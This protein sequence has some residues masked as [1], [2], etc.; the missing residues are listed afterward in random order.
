MKSDPF[1]WLIV[2]PSVLFVFL[3]LIKRFIPWKFCTVCGSIFL[4]WLILLVSDKIL[5]SAFLQDQILMTIL[6]GESVAG[7]YYLL[8]RTIPAQYHVF[9]FPILITLSIG[10][11]S[12]AR[13]SIMGLRDFIIL[14]VLWLVFILLALFSL[15]PVVR[16]RVSQLLACC[17]DW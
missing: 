2:I 12:L 3:S 8:L 13:W 11:Y 14:V 6:I 4:T 1:F 7:F 15:H 16:K 17:R 10:G 9:R 5:S